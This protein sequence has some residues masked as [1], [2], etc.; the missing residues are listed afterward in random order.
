MYVPTPSPLVVPRAGMYDSA[1]P[2]AWLGIRGRGR[3]SDDLCSPDAECQ[4]RDDEEEEDNDYGDGDILS[5]HLSRH[6]G[7]FSQRRQ[8]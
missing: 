3:R 5:H 7:V 1:G 2:I 6:Q 8:G 4:K